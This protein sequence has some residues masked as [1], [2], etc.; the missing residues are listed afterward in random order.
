MDIAKI[1]RRKTRMADTLDRAKAEN[2]GR[3]G[4]PQSDIARSLGVS[5]STVCRYFQ[6]I[7][8]DYNELAGYKD[9]KADAF[10]FTQAK[11]L[12]KLNC[13]LDNIR[14]DSIVAMSPTCKNGTAMMLNTVLGTLYDKERLERGQATEI[15]SYDDI[16]ARQDALRSQRDQIADALRARGIDIES[17]KRPVIDVTPAQD[18]IS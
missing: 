10:A 3:A 17:L 9:Y 12:S 13:V 14:E 16:R 1:D 7:G 18:S 4:L 6:K 15:I 2:L 5:P 8:L 11:A